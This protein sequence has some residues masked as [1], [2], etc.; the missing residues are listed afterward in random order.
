LNIGMKTC[1]LSAGPSQPKTFSDPN[2]YCY[3]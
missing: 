3:L 2:C 1:A